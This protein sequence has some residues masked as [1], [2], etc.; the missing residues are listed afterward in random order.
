MPDSNPRGKAVHVQKDHLHIAGVVGTEGREKKQISSQ[1]SFKLPFQTTF[2]LFALAV[3]NHAC[4]MDKA[5]NTA[6]IYSGVGSWMR[7]VVAEAMTKASEEWYCI[8]Q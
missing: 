4:L 7:P 1:V 2:L 5:F 3:H 8:A 6:M